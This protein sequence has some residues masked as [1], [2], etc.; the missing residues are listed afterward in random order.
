MKILYIHQYFVTPDE[1]GATRSYWF[2]KKLLERGHR[3]T[4]IT[5]TNKKTHRQAGR[6]N[7]EGI[8]VVYIKNEYDNYFS[9]TKKVWSFL[10]FMWYSIKMSL[11]EKDI[12]LVFATSTPLTVGVV[13]LYLRYRKGW[14]YIFEVRDL[15]PEFPIQIGAIK[16]PIL[17]KLLKYLEKI[18]YQKS[19]FVIALSPGMEDGVK[20]VG[21]PSDRVCVIP[22]MSKPDLFY[23]REK[24]AEIIH[25]FSLDTSKFN[26]VHFGSMGVANGLEYI[27]ET[28]KIL[29][30]RGV[31]DVNFVIAGYGITEPILQDL[32]RSYR[33]DNV[34]FLGQHNLYVISDIVNCCDISFTCFK[35]L[36]ILYTNSP[37][38]L[39]DSLSASKPIVVNSSGWTKELV[40]KNNCGFYVDPERP[41]DFADKILQYKGNRKCLKEWGENARYLSEHVFDKVI[42]S[43]KFALLIEN[44]GTKIKNN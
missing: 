2:A 11:K 26:I 16:K 39:F 37:N 27:I 42:L 12:D 29:K 30:D 3:V 28:A 24:S 33:L 22:N 1:D 38:K 17:I 25:K 32:A 10:K 14:K 7:I 19:E 23:S 6:Y 31:G 20:S 8:D 4:V 9:K 40:E 34:Q 36:P 21:I 15:W 18:I 44:I 43:E 13:A 41:K 5:S 35:N